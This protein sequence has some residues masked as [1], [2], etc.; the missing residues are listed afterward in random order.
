M[1][2]I[3]DQLKGGATAPLSLGAGPSPT[4]GQLTDPVGSYDSHCPHLCPQWLVI[5]SR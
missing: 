1:G 4:L 3:R 5:R 2:L